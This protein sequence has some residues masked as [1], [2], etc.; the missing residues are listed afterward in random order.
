MTHTS[1]SLDENLKEGMQTINM[2]LKIA[3]GKPVMQSVMQIKDEEVELN[4]DTENKWNGLFSPQVEI[5][6]SFVSK[7]REDVV[8]VH[9]DGQIT[10]DSPD[11]DVMDKKLLR[12]K[13]EK[14][15]PKSTFVHSM[16]YYFFYFR[17]NTEFS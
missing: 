17:S 7:R 16:F 2:T 6:D 4:K 1:S 3:Q 10:I 15:S 12:Y 11:Q 8:T 5:N 9:D 14:N 13:E